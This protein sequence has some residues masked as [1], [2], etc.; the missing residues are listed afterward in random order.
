MI[1][2]RET[3]S[4][5]EEIKRRAAA[6]A[7]DGLW[8]IADKQT[9]GKGRRGRCWESQDTGNLYLSLLLRP[10]FPKEC[11]SMVTLVMALGAAEA[12]KSVTAL[13][14]KIKWPN[15]IVI[16]GK[17]AVGILTELI[18][19]ESG[20]YYL[21]CGVGIN[22]NQRSFSTEIEGMATSLL[23]ECAKQQAPRQKGEE[24]DCQEPEELDKKLLAEKLKE[25]FEAVYESFCR[26]QDMS[27]LKASYEELLVN[28]GVRVRVLEPKG[29]YEGTAM[30]INNNGELLVER[31]DGSVEAVYAGE[32]S[33]RGIYG[34][35]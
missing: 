2:L 19:E 18:P 12:I 5:N 32:V 27:D 16:A 8:V 30:G 17:K 29:E 33:V 14:T 6:G 25:C 28:K 3:D 24:G 11:A 7:P 1:W 31:T 9:K 21:V 35:V 20:S 34:Y 4:T 13:D 23:Q 22:V 15:D 26:K 10:A